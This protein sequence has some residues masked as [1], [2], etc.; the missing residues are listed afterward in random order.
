[1]SNKRLPD[2]SRKW[3]ITINNPAD[4]DMGHDKLVEIL[5]DIA[6]VK[7]WC[8]CDEEGHE[9]TYHTH[10]YVDMKNARPFLTMQ[11]W[12]PGAHIEP[13]KGTALSNRNY[14]LKS[15]DQHGKKSDGSYDYVDDRGV[16]HTGVNFTDTFLEW[17]ELPREHQGKSVERAMIL[18]MIK[19]GND[20][21][22]IILEI[23][24]AFTMLSDINQTRS[25]LRDKDFKNKWRNLD[26]TYIFGTTG[27][28]KTRSVMEKYG[29][30]NVYRVTDYSHPFDAYEGQDVI[31][32][33]EFRSS[34]KH[35]D[36]LNYLD[37]YPLLLPCRYFNR[38]ACYS[39]VYLITNIPPTD[40]YK[41]IDQETRK[42]FFRR[43]HHVIEYIGPSWPVEYNSVEDWDY[44]RPENNFPY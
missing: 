18:E 38:Q 31:I 22:E 16:Q 10:L 23:P 37:G 11:S 39:K 35:A 30:Q 7:Y 33:E 12:F 25:I 14:V 21:E 43:I 5:E 32:F 42:A 28:G 29:Y 36:M 4:H 8:M 6:S 26:V 24:N 44:S 40:Q 13:C 9:G 17:G 41:N 27:S 19:A 20:N 2:Q 3:Q 15:G 1:M 34:L